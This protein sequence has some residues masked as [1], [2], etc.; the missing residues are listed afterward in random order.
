MTTI[1]YSFELPT[2]EQ[3]A[4]L[5]APLGWFPDRSIEQFRRSLAGSWCCVCAYD[6]D[7]LVGVGRAISD[8]VIHALLTEVA[9]AATHRR[10]GIGRTIVARLVEH[11]LEAGIRPIQLFAA[12][13]KVPF[14]Q[15][16]GFEVREADR[17]GM[18]YASNRTAEPS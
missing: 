2:A 1:H 6:G 8:G 4:A 9:V 17:P 12:A 7:Q 15:R 13:A 18:Q 16:L 5:F 10:R 14:Y 3:F 11:C